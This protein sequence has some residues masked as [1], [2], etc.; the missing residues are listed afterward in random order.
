M[1]KTVSARLRGA[2][3]ELKAMGEDTEGLVETT[4]KLRG[5]VKGMTGFDIME[6]E[7]T[8]KS[9]YD[10]VVGIGEKWSELTDIQQASLLESL[11]GKLQ[12]N[13]LAAALQNVDQIKEIYKTAEDSAGS[14][15]KEQEHYAESV[16]YSL[17]SFKA[18]AESLASTFLDSDF[19]KGFIDTGSRALD[20][21]EKILDA[22]GSFPTVAAMSGLALDKVLDISILDRAKGKY[23]EDIGI[24][25]NLSLD[26][27]KDFFVQNF[28]AQPIFNDEEV[29][30]L[31]KYADLISQGKEETQAF[32]ET[33]KD[34]RP[35]VQD[36]ARS[37]D[38]LSGA[39]ENIPKQNKAITFVKSFLTSLANMGIIM[40]VSLAIG[41]IV[42]GL[43]SLIV[44]SEEASQAID[45]LSGTL[46][47][48][49]S[50]HT[51]NLQTINSVKD[52]YYEL[53]EGVN[54]LGRNV[55]LTSEEYDEYKG[56]VS[57]ISETMPELTVRYNEQGEKVGFLTGQIR[58]LN[59]ELAEQEQREASAL[60]AD[61]DFAKN[62]KDTEKYVNSRVN[63]ANPFEQIGDKSLLDG[64]RATF[65]AL[66]ILINGGLGNP[67]AWQELDD[68]I[69]G[70]A[71][72]SDKIER[73]NKQIEDTEKKL[74][75]LENTPKTGDFTI[76]DSVTA[77]IERYKEQLG[78][79][80][81]ELVQYQ[82]EQDKSAEG[83]KSSVRAYTAASEE[84]SQLDE[85]QKQRVNDLINNMSTESA[86]AIVEGQE[87][88]T[89]AMQ[90]YAQSLTDAFA[91]NTK[92]INELT[93]QL[94]TLDTENMSDY[95]IQEKVTALINRIAEILGISGNELKIRW[96]FE[97]VDDN[98]EDLNTVARR[99]SQTSGNPNSVNESDLSTLQ[100]WIDANKVSLDELEAMEK[101]GYKTRDGLDALDKGL[102]KVRKDTK[103]LDGSDITID[104]HIK[105]LDTAKSDLAT[106]QTS[107][108]DYKDGNGT[109]DVNSLNSISDSMKKINGSTEAYQEFLDVLTHMPEDT[110]AVQKA[111]NKLVTEYVNGTG[112]LDN[113]TVANVEYTASEL[114][115]MGVVNATEVAYSGLGYTVETTEDQVALLQLGLDNCT[116]ATTRAEFASIDLAKATNSEILS[117]AQ[118]TG[119]S[120][121]LKFS[122]YQLAAQKMGVNAISLMTSGDISNL[123][124]LMKQAGLATAELEKLARAKAAVGTNTSGK[125]SF[126][127]GK[128][129]T[130]YYLPTADADKANKI[131]YEA[132][133]EEASNYVPS[134]YNSNAGASTN[135]GGGGGSSKNTSPKK[136]KT[137][138]TKK[139]K[140]SMSLTKTLYNWIERKLDVLAKKADRAKEKIDRLLDWNK[141]RDATVKALKAVEEQLDANL[142]AAKRYYKYAKDA[143]KAAAKEAVAQVKKEGSKAQKKKYGKNLSQATMNKY[144]NLVEEGKIGKDDIQA[145][146]DPRIKAFVDTYIE[147]YEKMKAVEDEADSLTDELK[148]LYDTLAHNPIDRCTEQVEK[149]N[150]Q[151]TILQGKANN[152]ILNLNSSAVN[153]AKQF[154]EI[155][156][157][158]SDTIEETD[159]LNS[160]VSDEKPKESSIDKNRKVIGLASKDDLSNK[161]F[162]KQILDT[163]NKNRGDQVNNQRKTLEEYNQ[164]AGETLNY[165]T[166]AM[167]NLD[168]KSNK[169]MKLLT[170]KTA[171]QLGISNKEYKEL[172][173]AISSGERI[174]ED[175][176]SKINKVNE[177]DAKVFN[178]YL[179]ASINKS[180]AKDAYEEAST[181]ALQYEQ[182]YITNYRDAM[183]DAGQKA[184][185]VADYYKT[186]FNLQERALSGQVELMEQYG[187]VLDRANYDEQYKIEEN[188][189]NLLK[190]EREVA[191][192]Y[193]TTIDEGST[194]WYEQLE[195]VN[196]LNDE[197]LETEGNMYALKDAA[198]AI[199]DTLY[200][201]YE[202]LNSRINNELQFL[203]DMME[204]VE[205]FD[206][207]S[208]TA[209]DEGLARLYLYSA[210]MENLNTIIQK[211]KDSIK[212]YE[213][214]LKEANDNGFDRISAN[215][216]GADIDITTKQAQ[217]KIDEFYDKVM[218]HT[219]D[220]KALRDS[221]IEWEINKLEEELNL[222]QEIVDARKDALT[223]EKNLH[224]YQRSIQDATQN[225]NNLQKQITVLSGDNSQEG[226]ARVQAL[227]KQLKD[228]QKNLE[229]TEYEKYISAEQEMLD[230]LMEEYT[231][232]IDEEKTQ[233]DELYERAK[234][235]IIL[236]ADK[237]ASTID[238]E[239]DELGFS[240]YSTD[241]T[242]WLKSEKITTLSSELKTALAEQRTA[243]IGAL[244]GSDNSLLSGLTTGFSNL[245]TSLADFSTY[246]TTVDNTFK[247]LNTTLTNLNEN[248]FKT[249]INNEIQPNDVIVKIA[250]QEI[251]IT[252]G[253]TVK[254]NPETGDPTGNSNK[255]SGDGKI[256]ENSSSTPD[257]SANKDNTTIT[258][259]PDIKPQNGSIE[260]VF[261]KEQAKD[262][263]AE[264]NKRQAVINFLKHLTSDQAQTIAQNG[265]IPASD[266]N[267]LVYNYTSSVGNKGLILKKAGYTELYDILGVKNADEAYQALLKLGFSSANT[268]YFEDYKQNLIQRFMQKYGDSPSK[269]IKDYMPVNKLLYAATGKILGTDELKELCLLLTGRK[270]ENS[271]FG[272][273]FFNA[274]W[275]K[276]K[277]IYS[278][279]KDTSVSYDEKTKK[280]KF[281]GITGFTG[282][283]AKGGIVDY[284]HGQ[285]EDGIAMVRQGEGILTPAQTKTFMYE[286][287]PRMD[288]IIDA[289][290]L[291]KDTTANLDKVIPMGETNVEAT[292]QFDL[293]NVTNAGD[294]IKQIQTNNNVQKA[295]QSVTIDRIAGGSRLGVNKF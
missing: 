203:V 38:D 242:E 138:K 80:R 63:G 100:Q 59:K 91:N 166:K 34:V 204:G 288:D 295:I 2:E 189:L 137:K 275:E 154:Y 133:Q 68:L 213:K 241:V 267:K 54:E 285:G 233:R 205:D 99:M 94:F 214:A 278:K 129:K 75:E 200:E 210:Q 109:V 293:E 105:T 184:K 248:G 89:V 95:E 173:D 97:Y 139:T 60:L 271:N 274:L 20:I 234:M 103:E 226:K 18:S 77:S 291:I 1:W 220:Y 135:G 127:K 93:K 84:Y 143:S 202:T 157:I 36:F 72:I 69:K 76:D 145:I 115:K 88:A 70:S 257:N 56:I 31:Q 144:M 215:I 193:L 23:G 250:D 252:N 172:N 225:I 196:S 265:S 190:D 110:E 136:T 130:T 273:L 148:E 98:V 240:Q 256:F 51:S 270:Y 194:Q 107:Y 92:G 264:S 246:K 167:A 46:D 260:D 111:Y 289:S 44:T 169:A 160:R 294:I 268:G 66:S 45:G 158:L 114:E 48:M 41:L 232:L 121:G 15:M 118:A 281:T 150:D 181:T 279:F 255:P 253:E 21:I 13:R 119:T 191:K 71:G 259:V 218:E 243:I 244:T 117:L 170:E 206:P 282:G 125:T 238:T 90:E 37:T 3:A 209:T 277:K 164:A 201:M 83:I 39:L 224:D 146:K 162:T 207:V 266:M 174:S 236:N 211:D 251:T 276:I 85:E 134:V 25:N 230:N 108:Q 141:K 153:M 222:A 155:N 231:T 175:I 280:L 24:Q 147:W 217:E 40:G 177:S 132:S 142:Q 8:Y 122:L 104:A 131:D 53:S 4:S 113:L 32:Y 123:V 120:N 49:N 219:K 128:N 180:S 30:A 261:A 223:A 178:D 228:A 101:Q 81:N 27:I 12:S 182:E 73:T 258:S 47:T 5:L 156:D 287:A 227:Q 78:E 208:H 61:E 126:G 290:K 292:F 16:Q 195:Y 87:N 11:A 283:F 57:Q 116:D 171:K 14:A 161:F 50:N 176:I 198:N 179:K 216:M 284:V 7:D 106:L 149:L 124:D 239:I 185:A 168:E 17:D 29:T 28:T 22:L 35:T 96:G 188:K 55:S 67:K 212:E 6:D 186:F 254:V 159:V 183:L 263:A 74:K 140:K 82:A 197:I 249:V 151:L 62:L 229:E 58:D 221:M 9:I 237:I 112:V 65:S 10:I 19:L 64:A 52:R 43:D 192:R 152:S 42:K 286:L 26:N 269:A 102:K 262:V 86:N 163:I 245:S 235:D 199:A 272:G 187:L 165:Y 247:S 33:L 79:L